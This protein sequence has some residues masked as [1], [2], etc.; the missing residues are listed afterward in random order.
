MKQARYIQ[1]SLAVV[2]GIVGFSHFVRAE[3]SSP[4]ARALLEGEVNAYRVN[5]R[6][7]PNL[8]FEILY[9]LNKGDKIK[10]ISRAYKWFK[11]KLPRGAAAFIS[12]DFVKLSDGPGSVGLVTG[13]NV[14]IRA[15]PDLSSTV[16]G[17]LDKGTKV[18]IRGKAPGGW[19]RIRPPDECAGWIHSDFVNTISTD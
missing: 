18:R 9:K 2:I 4:K 10:I 11:I 3:N 14:N 8:N 19:Y 12:S 13:N 7:G 15:R 6:S 16:L 17:Q 1:I 5:I